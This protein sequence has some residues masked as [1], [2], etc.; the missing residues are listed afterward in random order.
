MLEEQG[1]TT[2]HNL[3][4]CSEEIGFVESPVPNFEIC[5]VLFSMRLSSTRNDKLADLNGP[6]YCPS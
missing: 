4:L 6:A 5:P 3:V 1:E 2:N